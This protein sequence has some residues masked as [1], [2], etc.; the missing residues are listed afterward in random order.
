MKVGQDFP[1]TKEMGSYKQKIIIK[2]DL[3]MTFH[4]IWLLFSSYWKFIILK[5]DYYF[6]FIIILQ[7]DLYKDKEK[8]N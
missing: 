8:A 1:P 2:T 3:N 4:Y 5:T 6:N 7:M